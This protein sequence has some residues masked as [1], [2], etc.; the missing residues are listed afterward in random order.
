M[1]E[2]TLS[3]R[4]FMTRALA[5]GLMATGGAALLSACHKGGSQALSC[6]DLTGLTPDQVTTRNALHYNQ[7]S[8]VEGRR[9]DNCQQWQA[10]AEANTCGTCIIVP[11]PINPAGNCDSWVAKTT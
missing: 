3:R 6:D 4:D 10:P 11:G 1:S 2:Q 8:T 7:A 5:L 9:C